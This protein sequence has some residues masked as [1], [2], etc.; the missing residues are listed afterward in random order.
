[1]DP[2]LAG[3]IQAGLAAL[4]VG[5]S[6][7]GMPG[8]GIL[9]VPLMASAFPARE[10]VGVLLPV[11]MCGD[12]FAVARYRRYPEWR[13]LR[14]LLP[15]VVGGI[16]LG[17]AALKVL[18]SGLLEY[19]IGAM[20][21]GL[22]A[23]QAARSWRGEWLEEH[24]PRKWWFSA[25]MG[26]LAGFSTGVANL[27]GPVTGVYFISMGLRKHAFIGSAAVFFMA[28]NWIKVPFYAKLGLL[29]RDSLAFD[30][31]MFPLVAAG[32]AVGMLTF[33][34][35]PQKWFNRIILTLAALSAVKLLL[36]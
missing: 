36:F 3:L 2:G 16:V 17:A 22:I 14:R 18:T 11:L 23:L 31:R 26:A 33:R 25:S 5:F 15:W 4:L 21:L 1:M 20:V 28:V 30:L 7:T 29:T 9:I 27:A 8:L 34:Y 24:L 10:S 12:V 35:I 6:K 32:A 13:L 19:F